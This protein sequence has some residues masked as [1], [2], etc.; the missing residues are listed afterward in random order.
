MPH[1]LENIFFSLDIES[2]DTCRMVCADWRELLASPRYSPQYKNLYEE[3]LAE[4]YGVVIPTLQRRGPGYDY[5]DK[6]L[7]FLCSTGL[8]IYVGIGICYTHNLIDKKVIEEFPHLT[9]IAIDMLIKFA[10]NTR[11]CN[12]RTHV[13]LANK[14]WLRIL[15]SILLTLFVRPCWTYQILHK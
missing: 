8:I 9:F 13:T 4:N 14:C 1:I 15:V 2:F 10:T 7:S 12:R 3:M 6:L 5:L 11:N